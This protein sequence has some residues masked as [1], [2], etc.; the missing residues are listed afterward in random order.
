MLSKAKLPTNKTG[1]EKRKDCYDGSDG[2]DS[3]ISY[4][5]TCL[6]NGNNMTRT[7]SSEVIARDKE[8]KVTLEELVE[9]LREEA[10]A[11]KAGGKAWYKT[12]VTDSDYTEFDIFLKW[13]GEQIRGIAL[14]GVS[15]PREVVPVFARILL[16]TSLGKKHLVRTLLRTEITQVVNRCLWYDATKLTTEVLNLYKGG[17]G[18][19][20]TNSLDTR[21][22]KVEE[23]NKLEFP[24]F[25][26]DLY[27]YPI[28]SNVFIEFCKVK[29]NL[30]GEWSVSSIVEE[31]LVAVENKV[32]MAS[33]DGFEN[34]NTAMKLELSRLCETVKAK[35]VILRITQNQCDNLNAQVE[36][37]KADLS[38]FEEDLIFVRAAVRKANDRT[39]E[40][41][42]RLDVSLIKENE[43]EEAIKKN[44]KMLKNAGA[45]GSNVWEV[46]LLAL[47]SEFE[48]MSMEVVHSRKI[49]AVIAYFVEEVKRLELKRD[50]LHDCLIF[51]GCVCNADQGNCLNSME[52]SIGPT[53]LNK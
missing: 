36:K 12:M 44:D 15:L 41:G 35:D 45:G 22:E 24:D 6:Q 29:G 11:I 13:L 26:G 40:S 3:N 34:L 33:P 42:D 10:A 32:R 51:K 28:D 37:L 25:P 49:M 23:K 21:V 46:V 4:P 38:K 14:I 47:C 20:I 5:N 43:L 2:Y 8:D 48:E 52:T 31:D 50:T 27:P 16:R 53:T 9:R 18:K 39:R 1:A 7:F 30:C 17:G 19:L